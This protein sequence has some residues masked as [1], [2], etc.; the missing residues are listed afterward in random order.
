MK[1]LMSFREQVSLLIGKENLSTKK[2]LCSITKCRLR[3]TCPFYHDPEGYERGLRRV[4]ETTHC[5]YWSDHPNILEELG[6][7]TGKKIVKTT[8]TKKKM[9]ETGVKRSKS[10]IKK[11]LQKQL[12]SIDKI[13]KEISERW[14]I[15]T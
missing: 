2:K 9:M 5:S 1:K 3:K 13:L 12:I 7:I 8:G 6:K 10:V 11:N 4:K 14:R 15:Q